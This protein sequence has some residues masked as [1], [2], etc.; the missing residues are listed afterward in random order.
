MGNS[1]EVRADTL[2]SGP[3][4]SGESTLFLLEDNGSSD[5]RGRHLAGALQKMVAEKFVVTLVLAC[6]F[7]GSGDMDKDAED[8]LEAVASL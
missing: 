8:F 1:W 5:L 7:S 3:T 2:G 6:C 4:S